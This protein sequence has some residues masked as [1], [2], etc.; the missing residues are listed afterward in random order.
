EPLRRVLTSHQCPDR[1]VRTYPWRRPVGE[2]I[3]RNDGALAISE[4]P[5]YH[6]PAGVL[7]LGDRA[8]SGH[9]ADPDHAFPLG[10]FAGTHRTAT[11][12]LDPRRQ[13]RGS[14]GADPRTE[15]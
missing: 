9:G 14:R 1:E 2:G 13:G 5:P 7:V 12:D 10:P 4:E 8:D 15:Q 11:I 3:S 6:R